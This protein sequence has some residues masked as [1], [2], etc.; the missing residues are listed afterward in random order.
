M[1]CM[2]RTLISFGNLPFMPPTRW[3]MEG[4]HNSQKLHTLLIKTVWSKTNLWCQQ[5]LHQ[6]CS[7][8]ILKSFTHSW[9]RQCEVKPIYGAN[10]SFTNRGQLQ[11]SDLRSK[12]NLYGS[13]KPS[14]TTRCG[15]HHNLLLNSVEAKFLYVVSPTFSNFWFPKKK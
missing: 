8:T 11:F 10:K 7:T 9:S 3:R 2:T 6:R 15:L 12:F 4:N 14:T 5:E 13:S 1:K